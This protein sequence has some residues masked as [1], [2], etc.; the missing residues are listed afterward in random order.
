M[1]HNLFNQGD[2]VDRTRLIAV[3]KKLTET[4]DSVYLTT[5]GGRGIPFTRAM[6]NL[7][8]R[9]QVPSLTRFFAG[10]KG[11]LVVY[12]TTGASSDKVKHVKKHP[13]VSVYYCN[14]KAF[15]GLMLGGRVRIIK[16]AV[17]K[18]AVWQKGWERYY[19][20]GQSDPDYILLRLVPQVARGWYKSAP[21]T[22]KLK[23]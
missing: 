3:S 10:Q 15:H 23:G 20:G 12:F 22:L 6:L 1:G 9:K 19:P 18:R 11:E 16:D 21:F 14:P 13:Y 5:V 17:T 4:A 7:R 8:N 2:S